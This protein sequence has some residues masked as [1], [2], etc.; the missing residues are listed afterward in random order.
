MPLQSLCRSAASY[1]NSYHNYTTTGSP[2]TGGMPVNQAKAAPS[3]SS[4]SAAPTMADIESMAIK[5]ET[6]N[7]PGL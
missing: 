4:K 2:S 3:T 5:Q 6:L 7:W 1:A